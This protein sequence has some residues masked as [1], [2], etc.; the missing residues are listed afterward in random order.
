M[1]I[2]SLVVTTVLLIAMACTQIQPSLAR[3]APGSPAPADTTELTWSVNPTDAEGRVSGSTARHEL[4][5]GGYV[6]GWVTIS[7]FGTAPLVVEVGV[8]DGVTDPTGTVVPERDGPVFRP[9]SW[10]YQTP[11][12]RATVE[13]RGK[14]T[15][16]Y[17]IALPVDAESGDRVLM[18][19]A[20]AV[21][22]DG[23]STPGRDDRT[24]RID[25]R[26]TGRLD[27]ALLLGSIE[28]IYDSTLDPLSPGTV[29]IRYRFSNPGNLTVG[30]SVL[31]GLGTLY[32]Q[33]IDSAPDTATEI[34][35][36]PG[37]HYEGETTIPAVWPL[38][39]F[40]AQVAFFPRS[41]SG[42]PIDAEGPG[43]V[44]GTVLWAFPIAQTVPIA[45]LFLFA[46]WV[47]VV[48]ARRVRRTRATNTA[49]NGRTSAELSD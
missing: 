39:R 32:S 38:V 31:T 45:V 43:V 24:T 18:F 25:V 19:T 14:A 29:T 47:F 9:S 13:P 1:R 22:V 3:A 16:P 2:Q 21:D 40:D 42:T 49:E 15:V 41:I 12:T 26:V 44:D 36:V 23:T 17:D 7:N 5:P 4:D 20:S 48:R 27:P 35:L 11:G 6:R 37:S 33:R 28:P 8:Q 30:G 46:L 34:E 10:V